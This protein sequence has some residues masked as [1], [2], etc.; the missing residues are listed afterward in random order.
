MNVVHDHDNRGVL[1]RFA[2]QVVE[3]ASHCIGPRLA[4]KQH[5]IAVVDD[6]P[7]Q[8]VLEERRQASESAEADGRLP[9]AALDR[10]DGFA[11]QR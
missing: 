1:R 2:K 4:A 5:G 3:Q 7:S 8:H 6:V 9:G 11:R 10:F